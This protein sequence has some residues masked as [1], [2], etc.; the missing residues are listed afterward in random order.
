MGN[1][2]LIQNLNHYFALATL[3]GFVFLVLWILGII[4][5]SFLK[6]KCYISIFVTN[7]I[8]PIGFFI[9]L[10][11]TLVSLYYSDYLG[12]LPCGLCWFQRVFIYSQ[13]FLY[14]LAWYRNDKGM[15]PYSLVL[16]IFGIVIALYH[17]YLQLG[18]SELMPCPAIAST[19]DCARP[20]FIEYGFVTFPLASVVLFGF[21][22]VAVIISTKKRN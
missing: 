1:E 6:R 11:A 12:V 10:G 18:Y 7:F 3:L 15:L 2:I 8:L 17:E 14:G 9:T 22:I 4:G 19:I 5:T 16:S 13:V 20:T 21:L